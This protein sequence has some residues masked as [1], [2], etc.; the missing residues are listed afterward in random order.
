MIMGYFHILLPTSILLTV[1]LSGCAQ[2]TIHG[3]EHVDNN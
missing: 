2:T 3:D 1:I